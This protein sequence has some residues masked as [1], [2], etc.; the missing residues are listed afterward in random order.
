MD[1]ERDVVTDLCSGNEKV[2]A[3]VEALHGRDEELAAAEEA[4][5]PLQLR[6][7]DAL[8][9]VVVRRPRPATPIRAA[10]GGGR[11]PRGAR[12]QAAKVVHLSRQGADRLLDTLA[13]FGPVG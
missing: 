10:L 3:C 5:P 13:A 7:V 12:F 2:A 1:F 4:K 8:G 6:R 9:D 11:V